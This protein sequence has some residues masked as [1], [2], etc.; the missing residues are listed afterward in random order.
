MADQ[1]EAHRVDLAGRLL[2]LAFD[3][4]E[5]EGVLGPLVP[6]A[7]AVDGVKIEPVALGGR[8]PVVAF[9]T[10]D[11]LHGYYWRMI[12]SENRLPLF[13]IMR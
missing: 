3:L 6:I 13:R 4:V 8:A 2:D 12:L 7:F 11:A 5:R 9:R 10:D 1:F